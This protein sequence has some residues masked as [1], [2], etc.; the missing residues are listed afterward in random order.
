VER[1]LDKLTMLVQQ[2]DGTVKNAL[3]YPPYEYGRDG[4]LRGANDRANTVLGFDPLGGLAYFPM[5]ASVGAGDLKNEI[6]KDG[7][8][9]VAGVDTS[10]PLSRAYGTKA[11][12]GSVVMQGIPQAPDSYEIAAGRLVFLDDNGVAAPIPVG[13]SKIWCTGG[14]TLSTML[15]AER[16]V[17]DRELLWGR[18]LG[19]VVDSIAE[20]NALDINIYK[21]VFA[22]GYYA[23]GDGGGGA[24]EYSAGSTAT[25][26]GGRVQAA[27]G[28]VGRW[29][30]CQ[31]TPV[32]IKQY[33]A[34]LDGATDDTVAWLAAIPA[35][36]DLYHPGGVSMCRPCAFTNLSGNTVRGAGL[37]TSLVQ[38]TTPGTCWRFTD[39]ENITLEHLGFLPINGT[40]GTSGVIF[41]TAARVAGNSRVEKCQFAGFDVY[42]LACIGSAT[43]GLSGMKVKNNMLLANQ[44]KQLYFTWSH[45]FW[46][47]GNQ[48]GILGGFGHPQFGCFLDNSNAGTYV[49]N[50]HW[51]NSIGFQMQFSQYNRIENNRFEESDSYGSYIYGC[52]KMVYLGNT[53]HTNSEASKGT[54]DNVYFGLVTDSVIQGNSSFDWNGGS[55]GHRY[56]FNFGDGCSNLNIQGNKSTG[57]VTGPFGFAASLMTADMNGDDVIRGAT[58][59]TVA[60]GASRFFGPSG[61]G[62][63]LG[64][65][66]APVGRKSSVLQFQVAPDVA[67]GSGE[68]FT[69]R[70]YNNGSVIQTVTI[71]NGEQIKTAAG[72]N[73]LFGAGDAIGV[74][75]TASGGAAAANH[76]FALSVVN[77]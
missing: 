29:L 33:G 16:S 34:K 58:N 31:F 14:T 10:V 52:S 2:T 23:A 71:S 8:D 38:L 44:Q 75:V 57:W 22:L 11:N 51:N 76:R 61:G 43:F 27:A 48:Y 15:P 19:R 68:S 69:Y 26:N 12:L 47:E 62:A 49:Q 65:V 53:I 50:Y 9:Y 45:D 39:S 28:N 5:P 64:N 60:A 73:L 32:S 77:Y 74:Q 55:T 72:G 35:E 17:G 7:V 30:L 54:Y 70:L 21:R 63:T 46:I 24:Y 37:N 36:L 6:W 1:A 25:V 66:Q 20:L 18:T 56:G 40:G 13:V 59:G 4:T 3:R 41:D 67:P 42:G